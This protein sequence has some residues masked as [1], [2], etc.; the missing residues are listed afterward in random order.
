MIITF[1]SQKGGVAKTTSTASFAAD[2]R[3]RKKK[4][5]LIDT[6]PQ[7]NMTLITGATSTPGASIYEV[8]TGGIP[9][10]ECIQRTEFYGDIIPATK[11]LTRLEKELAAPGA[12][13]VMSQ[14][15]N[16]L[17]GAY[18]FILI[19]CP[20]ALGIISVS[21]LIAAD[22]VVVPV[23]ADILSIQSLTDIEDTIAAVKEHGNPDLSVLGI[24][25]TRHIGRAIISR[26]LTDVIEKMAAKM[27][28][29]VF[30]TPV[31]DCIAIREA[32]ARQMDIYNYAPRS[33]AA[34]DYSAAVKDMLNGIKK[35]EAK[36]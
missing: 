14:V 6:D 33:N 22:G 13:A 2:L 32:Q 19:D 35:G 27:D 15:L 28:T 20:P 18:D 24:L 10:V 36:R 31:R 11:P 29:R 3:R 30:N 17:K 1:C 23:L 5:L 16:P 26:D 21:A 9:A 4:T 34:A 7:C 12:A 8:L 25:I